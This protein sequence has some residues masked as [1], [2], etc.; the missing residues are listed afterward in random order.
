LA[1]GGV[2]LAFLVSA[3]TFCST[4]RAQPLIAAGGSV[5]DQ[6]PDNA[7][8]VLK[9]KNL[10]QTNKKVAKFAKDL[11]LD[12]QAP[13]WADPLGALKQQTKLNKGL[14]EAGDLAIVMVDPQ[15]VGGDPSKA[16][17]ALIP[18]TDYKAFVSNFQNPAAEGDITH[19]KTPD[20]AEDIYL[21]RW[22]SYAAASPTK[23]LLGKKPGGLKLQGAAAREADAKDA[24][25]IANIPVLKAMA[26]PK[27]KE[28]R[29]QIMQEIEQGL[30][31]N[32]AQGQKFTAVAKAVVGQV[33]NF[34]EEFL[35]DTRSAQVGLGLTDAGVVMTVVADFKPEARLGK[36]VAQAKNTDAPLIVG[37]PADR[38]Y[39]AVI[40]GVQDPQNASK[41]LADILDPIKKEL[42]KVPEAK[43]ISQAVDAWEKF[44]TTL[45]G[46]SMGYV[47]PAGQPRQESV[48][49]QVTVLQG[50]APTIQSAQRQMATSM[51][52]ILKMLPNQG[53]A[54]V[55]MTV[56]QG[57]RTVAGVKLDEMTTSMTFPPNDPNAKQ[58]Q[59]VFEVL[60]GKNNQGLTVVLGPIGPKTVVAVQGG[61]DQLISDVIASAK[62]G[63]P[64]PEP[65]NVKAVSAQL[66]KSRS[67]VAYIELD[68]ILNT[69]VRYGKEFF[70]INVKPIPDL[71]PIGMSAGTEQSALRVD[72]AVPM[73][74]VKGMVSW[75]I[76]AQRAMQNNPNGGL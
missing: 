9:V 20:G 71:P 76:E 75:G 35:N 8:V 70:P 69:G 5:L 40:G 22:G 1:V 62:A 13:E 16:V 4:A 73:D 68:N 39:F 17:V 30:A 72:L 11:G 44:D 51:N 37:L 27:L 38:K 48:L 25:V 49:Q 67:A 58:A 23:E 65:A 32:G 59:Q 64:L 74:L 45:T 26:L 42:D 34:A 47:I 21:A 6:V 66:P 18:V 29:E 3:T 7:I 56:K 15:A 12:Q 53:Q 10:A 46:Y 54:Q 19:A 60:Y 50:D 63:Q 41:V 36:L 24:V 33:L 14:N 28:G 31:Q 52:D 43:A 55:S 61:P 2:L 57:A